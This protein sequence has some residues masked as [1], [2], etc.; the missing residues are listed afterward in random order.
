MA[1]PE[2]KMSSKSRDE[3][4]SVH[5]G[6]SCLVEADQWAVSMDLTRLCMGEKGCGQMYEH[7]VLKVSLRH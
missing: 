6:T 3:V 4:P 7:I 2:M 1:V 5:Q